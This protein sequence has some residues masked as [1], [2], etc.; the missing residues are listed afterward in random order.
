[1]GD[2]ADLQTGARAGSQ[3][4]YAASTVSSGACSVY[5]NGIAFTAR[6]LSGVSGIGIGTPV[7]LAKAG[8][9]WFVTGVVPAAPALPSVPDQGAY[10]SWRGDIPPDPSRASV[11]GSL[12]VHPVSTASYRDGRWRT[13]IGLVDAADVVQGRYIGS[14]DGVSTGC[15]FYGTKAQVLAGATVTSATLKARRVWGGDPGPVTAALWCL[16]ETARPAGAPTL[17]ETTAGPTLRAIGSPM[18]NDA[19]AIPTSWATAMVAGTRGGVAIYVPTDDPYMV[20]A[21]I[22]SWTAAF[23]LTINWTRNF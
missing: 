4:G 10:P 7:L 12:V 21:G 17:N 13:D 5:V 18:E 14:S 6:V 23:A 19:F 20:L 16:T 3:V 9:S 2:W 8:S 1:M 11:S 15:V 22:G